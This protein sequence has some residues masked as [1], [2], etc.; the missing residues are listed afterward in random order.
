MSVDARGCPDNGCNG[1]GGGA[2]GG[3]G[4]GGTGGG[5][6][7]GFAS[8][9]STDADCRY[10][11][12]AENCCGVCASLSDP[13]PPPPDAG[14]DCACAEPPPCLCIAGHCAS[15][16]LP[17]GA[18]CDPGRDLCGWGL[19]C[20]AVGCGALAPDGGCM[21]EPPVCSTPLGGECQQPPASP[22]AGVPDASTLMCEFGDAFVAHFEK[23][24]AVRDDCAVVT[25]AADCCGTP[26]LA[27]VNG[28]ER[29]RF[30][31]AWSQ[32]LTQLPICD[33]LADRPRAEDGK[34]AS[35]P[36]SIRVDCLAGRCR[37]FIP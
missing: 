29:S 10:R 21:A 6:G 33:C 19:K 25:L 26:L 17:S 34:S 2:G 23:A 4:G 14:V 35:D 20:C 1:G 37:T 8:L 12:T 24:C 28:S 5:G 30:D 15:G 9:C 11:P 36:S 18:S 13:I 27:G 32:C 31:Q 3:G 16:D 22:D 7:G